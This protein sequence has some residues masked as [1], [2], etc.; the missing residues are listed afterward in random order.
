MNS[1]DWGSTDS[2]GR[3]ESYRRELEELWQH[4]ARLRAMRAVKASKSGKSGK[5]GKSGRGGRGGSAE[6]EGES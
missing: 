4:A 5:T 1:F 2:Q 6:G 3:Q